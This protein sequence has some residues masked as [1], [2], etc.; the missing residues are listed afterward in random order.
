[1]ALQ[2]MLAPGLTTDE[3]AKILNVTPRRVRELVMSDKLDAWQL[4][5]RLW[6]FSFDAVE[7]CRLALRAEATA[8]GGGAR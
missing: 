8:K 5:P 3:V 6:Y 7:R 2:P 4:L 1:M